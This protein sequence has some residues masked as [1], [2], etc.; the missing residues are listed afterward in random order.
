[1]M[2]NQQPMGPTKDY[3]DVSPSKKTSRIDILMS[4]LTVPVVCAAV[5][6]MSTSVVEWHIAAVYGFAV[7][8]VFR[9]VFGYTWNVTKSIVEGES[10]GI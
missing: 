2:K 3:A 8:Y 5:F 7:G 9:A 1:M 6:G 4:V 10:R